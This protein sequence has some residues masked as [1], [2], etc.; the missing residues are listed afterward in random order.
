MPC[1]QYACH[2]RANRWMPPLN[3]SAGSAYGNPMPFR[4]SARITL[5]NLDADPVTVYYQV[6]YALTA[7]PEDAAYL[8]AQW[9]RSNP[10]PYGDVHTVLDQSGLS[11]FWLT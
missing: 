2:A 8:H 10:V 11:H 6:D 1:R 3:A 5:T 4:R 9:R 7:V